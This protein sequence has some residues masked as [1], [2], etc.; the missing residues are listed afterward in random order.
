MLQYSYA[1]IIIH[2]YKEN[3]LPGRGEVLKLF[4]NFLSGKSIRNKLVLYFI[5]LLLFS[6]ITFGIIGN[7][8]YSD[9]IQSQTTSFTT[10][11]ISQVNKDVEI[12]IN[13]LEKTMRYLSREPAILEFLSLSSMHAPNRVDCE[14]EVRRIFRSLKDNH[15]EIAGMLIV[16]N[17]DIY[18]SNEIYKVA[19]DPLSFDRWYTLAAGNPGSIQLLSKPIGRNLATS[20][21]Y[22]PD[23]IVS[24]VFAV[25]DPVTNENLGVILIDMKLDTISRVISN[26]KPGLDGFIYISDAEG[27]LVYSPVNP[28][29]NRISHKWLEGFRTGSIKRE[30]SG[31][32]YQIMFSRSQ[33]TNWNTVGVFSMDEALKAVVNLSYYSFFIPI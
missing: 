31:I 6:M 16:N 30:I 8:I 26:I 25:T 9:R 21:D 18:I 7:L 23:D 3:S 17:S 2:L 15:P 5:S 11:M 4:H 12:Y 33:Y 10:D 19:R 28:V 27:N 1:N 32:N 22:T 29:V 13:S 20:L 24:I 14:T